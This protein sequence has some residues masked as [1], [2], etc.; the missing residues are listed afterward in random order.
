MI[1]EIQNIEGDWYLIHLKGTRYYQIWN[2]WDLFDL[3]LKAT[4]IELGKPK[5]QYTLWDEDLPIP[6]QGLNDIVSQLKKVKEENN[7]K[8]NN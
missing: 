4:N 6:Q 3:L 2:K 1:E 7:K 5:A 8:Y